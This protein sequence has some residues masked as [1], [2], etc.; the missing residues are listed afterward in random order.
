M[1][2]K[3][4]KIPAKKLIGVHITTHREENKI[5]ILWRQ[6]MP[7]RKDLSNTISNDLYS[8]QIYESLPDFSQYNPLLEFEYWAAIEVTKDA[9]LP[10]DME[11]LEL[12]GGLYAVFLYK[13]S[14]DQGSHMFQYIYGTWLP[15]SIYELDHR[16]H[17]EILGAKYKH[18]DPESEE[19]IWIP[20]RLKSNKN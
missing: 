6:F 1:Y 12:N 5:P 15:E 17:F 14:A 8:I 2:P 7:R 16:P 9:L 4:I 19:D 18:G 10:E 13:G 20:I 11:E 3:I